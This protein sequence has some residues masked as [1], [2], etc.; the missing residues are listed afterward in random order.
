[1]NKK[2]TLNI[3]YGLI[4]AIT[5]LGTC[6]GIGVAAGTEEWITD[7][8]YK[9]SEGDLITYQ[10]HDEKASAMRVFSVGTDDGR[11][12]ASIENVAQTTIDDIF[13]KTLD[14][15]R[16]NWVQFAHQNG[17]EILLFSKKAREKQ[18][19]VSVHCLLIGAC[20]GI[21]AEEWAANNV[22][23]STGGSLS[24]TLIYDDSTNTERNLIWILNVANENQF[25]EGAQLLIDGELGKTSN[26]GYHINWVQVAG[27]YG[28]E[29]LVLSQKDGGDA[30]FTSIPSFVDLSIK[31]DLPQ[32][33]PSAQP[34]AD[35]T[36]SPRN[37]KRSVLV[38]CA[39]AQDPRICE[40]LSEVEQK[41][42]D[43][44]ACLDYCMYEILNTPKTWNEFNKQCLRLH[45]PFLYDSKDKLQLNN[46]IFMKELEYIWENLRGVR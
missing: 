7:N 31:V 22:L 20:D 9:I 23:R 37:V 1:M 12:V 3:L 5:L 45:C 13:G 11:S 25:K 35:P 33:Q 34:S 17:N 21:S 38:T 36:S 15:Y 26:E 6:G 29:I 32:S 19:D 44:A 4:A 2:M 24:V 14:G 46:G 10:I 42:P 43:L 30:L 27:E 8:V 28:G 41:Y 18:V 16:V 39:N 40:H